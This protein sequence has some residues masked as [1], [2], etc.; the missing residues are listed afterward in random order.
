VDWSGLEDE[1]VTGWQRKLHIFEVPF[2]YIEYGL[3]SLGAFQ[4][5]ANAMKDQKGAVEAYRRA[6]ALGGTVSIPELYS[7]AGA[8]FAMD[9]EILSKIVDLIEHKI[10]E[11]EQF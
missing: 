1:M 2:Y 5:W 7:A 8:R 4:I 10:S 11:L 6:L 9:A 3:A